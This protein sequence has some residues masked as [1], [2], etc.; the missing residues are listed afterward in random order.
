MSKHQPAFPFFV[1]VED[2]AL[3]TSE[4]ALVRHIAEREAP[5]YG[6]QIERLR[7]VGQCGCGTCP[8]VF[9]KEPSGPSRERD[10]TTY[11]GRDSAKG[12]TAAVLLQSD[13]E[14]SQLEFY[15]V[16]GHDPW[17][18]PSL[19]TLRKLDGHA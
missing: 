19:E 10:I 17:S 1:S 12:L 11:V 3:T 13:G 7:V 6:A 15:S 4:E 9:F 16:D 14:L 18:P 2:R 5:A 8:T